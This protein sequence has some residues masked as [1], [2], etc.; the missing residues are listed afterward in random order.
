VNRDTGRV[1]RV[2]FWIGRILF[3]LIFIMSGL[4][5]F[6]QLEAMAE[7]AES[8]GVPAPRFF[9]G[10]SGLVILAGGIS[11]L[12]WWMVPIG[13]W[14]LIAFLIPAALFVHDFWAIEDPQ[15]KQTELAHFMKNLSLAGAALM[16]FVIHQAPGLT[17]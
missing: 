3:S 15:A 5:H 4:N 10:A 9:T 1:M 2:L 16:L 8:K 13:T 12:L 7:Y 14:L 6:G 11:I 17:G